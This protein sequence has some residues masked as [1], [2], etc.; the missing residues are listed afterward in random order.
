MFWKKSEKEKS[1]N[2]SLADCDVS[3]L[4]NNSISKERLNSSLADCDIE[5][6][7]KPNEALEV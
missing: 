3:F 7:K 5:D 6:I 1:L 2:S 4:Q